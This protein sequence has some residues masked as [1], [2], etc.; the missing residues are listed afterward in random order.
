MQYRE[1]ATDD[2]DQLFAWGSGW[3]HEYLQLSPGSLG[4]RTRQVNLQG[5]CFEWN[6][7]RQSILFREVLQEPALVSDWGA[8]C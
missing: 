5:L 6:S 3:D 8:N 1:I 7:Y 2:I 4:F